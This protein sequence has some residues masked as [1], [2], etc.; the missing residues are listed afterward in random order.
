M[1]DDSEETK[2]QHRSNEHEALHESDDI[3]VES[4]PKILTRI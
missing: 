3:G 2:F 4:V 1:K